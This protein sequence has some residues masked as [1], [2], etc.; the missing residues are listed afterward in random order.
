VFRSECLANRRVKGI[1]STYLLSAHNKSSS[2]SHHCAPEAPESP[3][4][5]THPPASVWQRS[6]EESD[7][8]PAWR[9]APEALLG[10]Q[11]S[12]TP[13]RGGD[14]GA[15]APTRGPDKNGWLEK[16]TARPIPTV[17]WDTFVRL[18]EVARRFRCQAEDPLQGIGGHPRTT[19]SNIFSIASILH[20]IATPESDMLAC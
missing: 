9:F 10:A 4:C 18:H 13:T 8:L 15:S 14:A 17:P 5:R 7:S 19:I 20:T 2:C 3:G 16:P 1:C 11:P 12:A 6:G